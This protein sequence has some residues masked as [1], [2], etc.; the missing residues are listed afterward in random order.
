MASFLHS[1]GFTIELNDVGMM[2]QPIDQRDHTGGVREYLAPLGKRLVG[3]HDRRFGFV[4][5]VDDIEEQAVIAPLR[6]HGLDETIIG[7]KM[8]LATRIAWGQM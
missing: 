3:C 7:G 4:A 1:I 5:S 2:D 8:H 6:L